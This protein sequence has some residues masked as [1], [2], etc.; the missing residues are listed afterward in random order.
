MSYSQSL[1]ESV[2]EGLKEGLV[3]GDGLQNV[4]ICSDVANGPLAQ[5]SATQSEDITD[6]GRPKMC[7]VREVV[8]MLMY[9]D[10]L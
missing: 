8:Y 7:G 9:L 5:P 3:V 2:N 1:P 10:G 4:P 6:R